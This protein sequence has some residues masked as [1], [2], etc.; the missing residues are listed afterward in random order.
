MLTARTMTF[1]VFA[2]TATKAGVVT[3]KFRFGAPVGLC[4]GMMMIVGAIRAVHV[5]FW[6]LGLGSGHEVRSGQAI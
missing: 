6:W 5:R 1:F 4:R 2:T 3:P